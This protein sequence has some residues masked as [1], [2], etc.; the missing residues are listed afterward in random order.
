M[1]EGELLET[2]KVIWEVPQEIVIFSD[3][4][5]VAESDYETNARTHA[6]RVPENSGRALVSC[7]ERL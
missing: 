4:A 5:I 3:N 6:K 7:N 1:P 2:L